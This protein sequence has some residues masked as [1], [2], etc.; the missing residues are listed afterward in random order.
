MT[1]Y[2]KMR[3]NLQ[4]DNF[5]DNGISVV[6]SYTVSHR[7]IWARQSVIAR[8]ASV[9]TRPGPLVAEFALAAEKSRQSA[10]ED[11]RCLTNPQAIYVQETTL[12]HRMTCRPDAATRRHGRIGCA[13]K[14]PLRGPAWCK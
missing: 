5:Y 11:W 1:K 4:L 6:T 14:L 12:V 13:T 9:G 2:L 10:V 7:N 3:V 8:H